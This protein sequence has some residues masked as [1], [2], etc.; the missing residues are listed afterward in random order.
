MPDIPI[1]SQIFD[2]VFHPSHSTVYT[3]L[4]S[5]KVQAISYDRAGRHKQLFSVKISQKSCRGITI[6]EDG[7]KLYIVG[8]GKGLHTIDTT[9]EKLI[10]SRAKAH[11]TPINRVKHVAPWLITTGDDDGVI[12]LWD[13]RKHDSIRT[14]TQHFDYITDFL[15]LEDKKHLVATSGDGTLSVIDVRS[16]KAEPFAHSEDQEDE[17]LSI[18]PIKGGTKAL[19][20]TQ[21][22]IISVFNRSAGWGDCVDRIPGH[23]HSVDAL[24]NLPQSLPNVD[25]STTIL[26]GSSDGFMRAVEVFPTKL[27]GVVA[28]HG[29]WPVERISVGEGLSQLSL[30]EEDDDASD[31]EEVTPAPSQKSAKGKNKNDGNVHKKNESDNDSDEEQQASGSGRWWAG[32]VGH[33]EVLKLTDLDLF[34]NNP[35]TDVDPDEREE[36]DSDDEAVNEEVDPGDAEPREDLVEHQAQEVPENR[37]DSEDSDEEVVTNSKKRKKKDKNPLIVKKKAGKNELQVEGSF[38]NDL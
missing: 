32:S 37:D 19:V 38:F 30:E 18:V 35:N 24:C 23:P 34:F 22:G 1:G 25:A 16:N 6:N 29:D 7:S 10:E 5:G 36:G 4:L 11:E 17:L 33:D 27:H 12:K 9:T 15:W 28:D 20:G 2:L 13:P 21:L 3:A 8:K 26:T 14:Y 31:E